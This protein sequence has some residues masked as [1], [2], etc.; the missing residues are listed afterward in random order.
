[1]LAE[2]YRKHLVGLD[3]HLLLGMLLGLVLKP[4]CDCIMT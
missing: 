1:M 2:T 3:T 4:K